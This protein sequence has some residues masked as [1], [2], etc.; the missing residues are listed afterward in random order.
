MTEQE[1]IEKQA[2][3]EISDRY[4]QPYN[5]FAEYCLD[6]IAEVRRL[7]EEV[8]AIKGL[9]GYEDY[10]ILQ[11]KNW[12]LNN[13]LEQHKTKET[14]LLARLKKVEGWNEETR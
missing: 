1:L 14:Y 7:N 6:L 2:E 13:E 12:E 9:K 4:K 10:L 8:K 3:A 5:I 11:H